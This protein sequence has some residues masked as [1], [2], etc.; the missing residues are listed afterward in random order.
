MSRVE[1]HKALGKPCE[2]IDDGH[3]HRDEYKVGPDWLG[4]DRITAVE[5]DGGDSGVLCPDEKTLALSWKTF[6]SP[7]TRP[8][9]LSWLDKVRNVLNH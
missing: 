4:Y 9:W 2:Q 1:V 7:H 5:F 8:D 3:F 6:Y